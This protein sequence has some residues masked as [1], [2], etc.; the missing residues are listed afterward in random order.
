MTR[1]QREISW[2]A[3]QRMHTHGASMRVHAYR[4]EQTL[5]IEKFACLGLPVCLQSRHHPLCLLP[6]FEW[7]TFLFLPDCPLG[8]TL[9]DNM[10]ERFSKGTLSKL[11]QCWFARGSALLEEPDSM[12]GHLLTQLSLVLTEFEVI[13]LLITD[14]ILEGVGED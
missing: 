12:T 9:L 8:F 13:L 14:R 3:K 2:L 1:P 7:C 6:D 11:V 10:H 4:R 5:V